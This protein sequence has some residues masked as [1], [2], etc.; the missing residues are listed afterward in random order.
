M[1]AKTTYVFGNLPETM[2]CLLFDEEGCGDKLLFPHGIC[3]DIA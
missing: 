2:F 3:P 1:I